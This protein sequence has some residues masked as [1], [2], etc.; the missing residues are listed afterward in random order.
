MKNIEKAV[1]AIS[2]LRNGQSISDEELDA[3]ISVL[4]EI[5]PFLLALGER[6][7]LFYTSMQRDLSQLESFRDARKLY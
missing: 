3:G 1:V 7:I 6:Y 4:N 2:K 5:V